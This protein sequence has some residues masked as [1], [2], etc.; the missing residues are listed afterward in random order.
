VGE[1]EINEAIEIVEG[2]LIIGINTHGWD[3]NRGEDTT[4]EAVENAYTGAMSL[5]SRLYFIAAE[6]LAGPA[7]LPRWA[8]P[9]SNVVIRYFTNKRYIKCEKSNLRIKK[10][11]DMISSVV[12][13]SNYFV[14]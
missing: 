5:I 6:Y 10:Y 7:H 2:S 4:Q 1:A 9:G 8:V 12:A 14:R 11:D 3:C 13:K